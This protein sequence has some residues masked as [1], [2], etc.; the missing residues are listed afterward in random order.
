MALPDEQQQ[1]SKHTLT[2]QRHAQPSGQHVQQ[3][4]THAAAR[5]EQLCHML[6]QS[7]KVDV[8]REVDQ[9][10]QLIVEP[11]QAEP[12]VSHRAEDVCHTH[13]L[14]IELLAPNPTGSVKPAL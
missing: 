11:A 2:P 5:I 4:D 12:L 3:C 8:D 10:Q 14:H 1:Q 13:K 6:P 7:Q 9:I